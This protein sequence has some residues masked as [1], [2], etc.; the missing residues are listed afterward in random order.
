MGGG[1]TPLTVEKFVKKKNQIQPLWIF[2]RVI[3]ILLGNLWN[4]F[5]NFIG[6]WGVSRDH[7]WRGVIQEIFE[8]L[9]AYLSGFLIFLREILFGSKILPSTCDKHQKFDYGCSIY[10]GN[11]AQSHDL[12]VFWQFGAFFELFVLAQAFSLGHWFFMKN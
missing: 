8:V 3:K 10:P 6:L 11:E 2:A 5:R 7:Y 9:G 1:T 4:N 12:A